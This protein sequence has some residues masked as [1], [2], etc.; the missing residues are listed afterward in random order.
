MARQLVAGEVLPAVRDD[1]LLRELRILPDDDHLDRLARLLVGHAHH[2]ALEHAG[3]RG[4]HALDLVRVHVEARHQ[5][6]VL[7][8]VG[9]GDVARGIHVAEVARLQPA[10]L[11][12]LGGFL[13]VVPVALHHLRPADADLAG[14]LL[15]VARA[16]PRR[17][18]VEGVVADRQ[19]G[20]G[21][22]Q[23]DGAVP[24]RLQRIGAGARRGLGQAV[25]LGDVAPRHLLPA[26]GHRL[27]HGGAAADDHLHR[28]EV[29]IPE[30]GRVQQTVEQRVDAGHHAPLPLAELL[31]QRR[32]VARVG[33]RARRGCPTS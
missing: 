24:G 11:Q 10:V 15:E 30:S 5:D 33:D 23:A 9:D 12:H 29:E 3:M 28:R 13:R 31:D 26:F 1:G 18:L 22:G 17:Q 27:L 8:A 20:R 2:A 6:H 7:L 16:G 4:D 19:L 14:V 32:Q 21:E 25:G